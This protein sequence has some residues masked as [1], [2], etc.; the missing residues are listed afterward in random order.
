MIPFS[1]PV[2]L[3][4]LFISNDTLKVRDYVTEGQVVGQVLSKLELIIN[5]SIEN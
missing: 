1:K 4:K 3:A 2:K 5:L